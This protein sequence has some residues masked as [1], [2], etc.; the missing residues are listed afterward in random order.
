MNDPAAARR[1]ERS[2]G[3]P[4]FCVRGPGPSACGAR[5]GTPRPTPSADHASHAHDSCRAPRHRHRPVAPTLPRAPSRASGCRRPADPVVGAGPPACRE[6]HRRRYPKRGPPMRSPV[7]Q[8]LVLPSQDR[9]CTLNE[10]CSR[11]GANR[12]QLPWAPR[13]SRGGGLRSTQ[14]LALRRSGPMRRARRGLLV[15]T[16]HPTGRPQNGR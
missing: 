15:V 10:T 13:S 2:G 5:D 6:R 9:S 1:S 16:S 4:R 14:R 11:Q 3:G 7:A 12:I 8:A